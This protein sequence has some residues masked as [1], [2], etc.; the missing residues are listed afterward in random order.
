MENNLQ[1]KLNKPISVFDI[2][3]VIGKNILHNIRHIL[4]D[5]IRKQCELLVIDDQYSSDGDY[6]PC[7]FSWLCAILEY[8]HYSLEE[9][10]STTKKNA[11]FEPLYSTDIT[12]GA[13]MKAFEAIQNSDIHINPCIIS[14]KDLLSSNSIFLHEK[15]NAVIIIG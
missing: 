5:N 10:I 3:A 8:G 11:Y 7:L 15:T 14:Q 6:D 4:V 13:A 1:T 12:K 2:C 9:V